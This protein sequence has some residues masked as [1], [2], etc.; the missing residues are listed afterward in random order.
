M[1]AP[2][3]ICHRPPSMCHIQYLYLQVVQLIRDDILPNSSKLPR[4]FIAKLM[5][6]LNRGSIHSVTSSS[7]IGN[8]CTIYL[9]YYTL[10][11]ISSMCVCVFDMA[12]FT[13]VVVYIV[14]CV[15]CQCNIRVHTKP[16][17]TRFFPDSLAL[18]GLH[19]NPMRLLKWYFYKPV[20]FAVT[21]ATV[22][23]H[24]H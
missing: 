23:K 19:G 2:P 11:N 21:R 4:D 7:F 13:T 20:G 12:T 22:S 3:S 18:A 8:H 17:S 14:S 15:Y 6:I 1:I 5:H 9:H 10:Y 16:F 24:C